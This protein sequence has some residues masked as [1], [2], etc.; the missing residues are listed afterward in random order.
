MMAGISTTPGKRRRRARGRDWYMVRFP[1]HRRLSSILIRRRK[2]A[3]SRK[4]AA[5]ALRRYRPSAEGQHA[6]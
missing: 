5:G 3:S 2:R 4:A 1:D 6:G